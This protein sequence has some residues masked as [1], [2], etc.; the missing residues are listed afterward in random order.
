MLKGENLEIRGSKSDKHH[1]CI[2]T[3]QNLE[4]I[5]NSDNYSS[6]Y[7]FINMST[8]FQCKRN[9]HLFLN[10]IWWSENVNTVGRA[11]VY[12]PLDMVQDHFLTCTTQH[13]IFNSKT[14]KGS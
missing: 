9:T 10:V 14:E 13:D 1:L 7:A 8:P 2:Y 5:L 6:K 4:L 12:N 11:C 3:I